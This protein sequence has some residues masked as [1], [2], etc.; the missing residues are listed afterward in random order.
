MSNNPNHCRKAFD[1]I[2]SKSLFTSCSPIQ[3]SCLLIIYV[4]LDSIIHFRHPSKGTNTS[5]SPI[6][7]F[8]HE[9]VPQTQR[10]PSLRGLGL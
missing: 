8:A 3:F 2:D 5:R 6:D 9:E 10:R 7:L 4:L 1:N